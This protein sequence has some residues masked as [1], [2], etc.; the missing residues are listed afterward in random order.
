MYYIK[1][2]ENWSFT[3]KDVGY[4]EYVTIEGKKLK[5]KL[6][7]GNGSY[8]CT[9]HAEKIKINTNKK[10]VYWTYN[11]KRF[12]SKLQDISKVYRANTAGDNDDVTERRPVIHL[13]VIFNGGL[14]SDVEIGLD[15]RVR[16]HSDLLINRNTIRRMNVSVNPS[17]TFVLSRRIKPID[18]GPN[19]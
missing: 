19:K 10:E 2:K 18:K 12:K 4:V 15:A 8:A 6:D 7:T 13:D 16:S 14:Y 11:K 9:F 3:S 5:A 17:R 1:D